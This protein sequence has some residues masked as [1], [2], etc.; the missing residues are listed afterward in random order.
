MSS[1]RGNAISNIVVD[2]VIVEGVPNIR[3]AVFKHFENHFRSVNIARPNIANLQFKFI[4]DADAYYLERPF[5]EDEV[6]QAVWEC[7]SLKSPGPDGVNFGFIKELWMDVKNDF[8]RFLLEFYSNNRL[9]KGSNCTFIVLIPKVANPRK[10]SD[11]R[12]ISLVGCMYKILDDILIA[13][14]AVDD[15]K[16]RKKELLL[17]KVDFEKVYD[18]VDWKYLESV[19]G[20]MGFS[21]KW[22]RWIMTCVSSATASVLVNGSPMM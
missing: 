20:K 15:A 14:E 12:P 4:S 2:N 18:S 8:M 7:D 6:K 1:R 16:K 19:M 22:R 13:N 11:F 5:A 21:Y 3:E 10:M 9:V 17:F